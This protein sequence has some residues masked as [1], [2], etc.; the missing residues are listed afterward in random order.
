MLLRSG[1]G[2]VAHRKL[3][4][5]L[6][7]AFRIREVHITTI[8]GCPRVHIRLCLEIVDIGLLVGVCTIVSSRRSSGEDTTREIA[9][10]LCIDIHDIA[11]N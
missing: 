5:E 9:F 3:K 6:F 7:P 10:D 1:R 2:V 4:G 11:G 8:T